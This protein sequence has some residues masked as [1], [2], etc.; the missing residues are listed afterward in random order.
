MSEKSHFYYGAEDIRSMLKKFPLAW[1]LAWQDI[2]L[3][4]RRSK[5]GPFWITISTGVIITMIGVIFGQALKQPAEVYLPYIACGFVFWQFISSA[6]NE[7]CSAFISSSG[8]IRQIDLPLSLHLEK[9]LLKNFI[10]L[11]H[12]MILI[13]IVMLVAGKEPSMSLFLIV[14]GFLLLVLNIFW[15]TLIF[16]VICTRFRDMPPIIASVIQVFFYITPIIWMPGALNARTSQLLVETNPCYHVLE[17]VRAPLLG[18]NPSIQS[19]CVASI[20]ALIG[21]FMA[22][23]FFGKYKFRIAYW[24]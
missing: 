10:I 14:P 24:V 17:L 4:Y 3:R 5:L 1:L 15:I 7:G 20:S 19:W 11:C 18:Y 12:N 8:M 6:I 2:R 21:V 22:T 9:T 16:G 23:Y 13:P